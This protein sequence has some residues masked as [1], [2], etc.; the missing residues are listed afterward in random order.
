MYHFLLVLWYRWVTITAVAVESHLGSAVWNTLTHPL[1]SSVI[2]FQDHNRRNPSKKTANKAIILS[3]TSCSTFVSTPRWFSDLLIVHVM[4]QW[5]CFALSCHVLSTEKSNLFTLVS[6]SVTLHLSIWP[7]NSFS[8]EKKHDT[9]LRVIRGH[10][11]P[12]KR[13]FV[14]ELS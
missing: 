3:I 8:G 12:S 1:C 11:K 10:W 9:F 4:C 2:L 14:G 13:G 7:S 6:A 5:P